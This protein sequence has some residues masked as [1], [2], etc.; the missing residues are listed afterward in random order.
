MSRLVLTLYKALWAL[1][2][3]L[4]G[5]VLL[6]VGPSPLMAVLYLAVVLGSLSVFGAEPENRF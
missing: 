2:L 5:V 4:Q 6:E 1:L 3:V